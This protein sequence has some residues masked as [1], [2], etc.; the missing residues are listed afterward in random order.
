MTTPKLKLYTEHAR[1]WQANRYVYPVIS[2]RS[3]GL[4][5]G[6]NLNPDKVC[7]F[8]CIYCCVDRSEPPVV[9]EVDLAVLRD[10]LDHALTLADSGEIFQVPPLDQTPPPLRR[11]NDVAFS[12]DGEPTSFK[13]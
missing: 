11:L 10:E 6:V 9:R 4:S 1:T 2:R 12:G 3:Q 8:D 7:N 13:E 5:I